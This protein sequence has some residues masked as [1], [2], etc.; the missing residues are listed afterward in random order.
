[1][2]IA[3]KL[4]EFFLFIFTIKER[5]LSEKQYTV[6]EVTFLGRKYGREREAEVIIY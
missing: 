6:D 1:M 4:N 5:K 2:K 3:Q